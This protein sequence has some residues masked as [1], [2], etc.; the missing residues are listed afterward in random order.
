[1]NVPLSS[2]SFF[3]FSRKPPAEGE[4]V[5]L[6]IDGLEAITA[7]VRVNGKDAGP[8]AFH[9]HGIEI[10][11][12]VKD[13]PDVLEIEL[14]N[15]N[16]NLLGPHHSDTRE[17]LSVGPGTFKSEIFKTHYNFIPFG[18]TGGVKVVYYR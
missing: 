10:T 18:I 16:R 5:F 1:M 14:T 3:P 13:G 4:K 15:S 11:D 8:I 9:P 6:E 2:S 7:K 12:L 17:P